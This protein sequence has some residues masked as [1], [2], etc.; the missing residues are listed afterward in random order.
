MRALRELFSL[1]SNCWV[2]N[3]GAEPAAICG[4][5]S[6]LLGPARRRSAEKER[7]VSGTMLAWILMGA[8]LLVLGGSLLLLLWVLGE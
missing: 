6:L 4:F 7:L 8:G 1:K 2:N 3:W 5:R